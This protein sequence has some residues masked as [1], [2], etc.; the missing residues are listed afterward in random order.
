[1]P[2]I[3]L[4]ISLILGAVSLGFQRLELQA[5]SW[6]MARQDALGLELPEL[7]GITVL[8]EKVDKISCV[9]LLKYTPIPIQA[10]S[11]QLILGY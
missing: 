10:R 3:V 6:S 5:M 8:I 7:A 9:R 2:V 1:M 4:G 11:C